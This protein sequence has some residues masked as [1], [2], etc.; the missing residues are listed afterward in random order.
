MDPSSTSGRRVPML[1]LPDHTQRTN[2]HPGGKGSS[3]GH[4]Q[5]K[6]TH[7]HTHTLAGCPTRALPERNLPA[8]SSRIFP[9]SE[10]TGSVAEPPTAAQQ[11]LLLA[12]GNNVPPGRRFYAP[13]R[14][15][16]RQNQNKTK[17]SNLTRG[18]AP[19]QSSG[20]TFRRRNHGGFVDE[21]R[22][23]HGGGGCD[24]DGFKHGIFSILKVRNHGFARSRGQSETRAR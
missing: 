2:A 16:L 10:T 7:K 23:W 17:L 19:G 9:R 15:L 22:R 12:S 14:N 20:T 3:R 24:D 11:M 8:P 6:I 4:K 13:Q 18:G 21:K 5:K 1:L